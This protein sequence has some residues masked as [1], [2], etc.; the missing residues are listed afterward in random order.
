MAKADGTCGPVRRLAPRR[1]MG[2]MKP[3]KPMLLAVAATLVLSACAPSAEPAGSGESDILAAYGL[4]GLDGREIVD[5]L[6]RTPVTDRPSGLRASVRP[7]ALLLSE[8]G[9]DEST[10]VE[11]PLGEF[12]LSIAPYVEKTHDCFYHSLTTCRGE[13]GGQVVHVTITNRDTGDVLVDEVTR[14]FDNGFVA[15]WLPKGINATVS[16]QHEGHRASHD[17]ATG[18]DDPTCL[19]TVHLEPAHE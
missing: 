7:D 14:T 15:Y 16:V 19:T 18:P 10:V 13:L 1:K 11:L 17:I 5:R 2:A 3:T 8:A 9:A 12:Y 6:D 4:S